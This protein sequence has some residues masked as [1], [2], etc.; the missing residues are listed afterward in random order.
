LAVEGGYA[1]DY[2]NAL[3][4]LRELRYDIWREFDTEDSMRFY[5]L[6]ML[7]SEI[8]AANPKD[9]IAKGTDWRFIDE[10]K[11]ELKA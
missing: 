2:D 7:E 5:A 9:L 4:T 3:Q 8:I 11:R 6:R 10:L 1:A